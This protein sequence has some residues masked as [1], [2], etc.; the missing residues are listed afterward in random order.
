M[1]G[2]FNQ[3]ELN[4]EQPEQ[5]N[6]SEWAETQQFAPVSGGSGSSTRSGLVWSLVA[7]VAIALV[8]VLGYLAWGVKT[9]RIS[10]PVVEVAQ[11]S[12]SSVEQT[13]AEITSTKTVTQTQTETQVQQEPV[14]RENSGF[15]SSVETSR[16]TI[17][18]ASLACDGHYVVIVQSVIGGNNSTTR[19]ELARALEQDSD[20]RY[21]TPGLCPSLR[22][23]YEDKDVYAVYFDA[24]SAEE[25]CSLKRQWGGNV[26]AMKN[27]T[28]YHSD[29]C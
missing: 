18:P 19:Q 5:S 2:N 21:A 11:E 8:A 26:R 6:Q 9:E 7:V 29:P 22:P 27:E 17:V 15:I 23:S 16:G 25:A 28:D 24:G 4:P 1:S 12:S 3:W 13:P 20:L 10:L 14:W